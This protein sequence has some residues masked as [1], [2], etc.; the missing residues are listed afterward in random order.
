MSKYKTVFTPEATPPGGHYSQAV[1]V[2]ELI[3]VSGQLGFRPGSTDPESVSIEQQ[4]KNC[5]ANIENILVA[6]GSGLDRVVKTTVYISDMALWPRVNATY[7]EVFG[8]LKPARAVVPSGKLHYSFD[9]EI[10][11]IATT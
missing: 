6:S 4:T 3:F 9:V 5:L 1:I 8:D 11:A 2:G 7:A 10:E